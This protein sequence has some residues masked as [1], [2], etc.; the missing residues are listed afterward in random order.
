MTSDATKYARIEYERTFLVRADAD[1][2]EVVELDV[3]TLDDAYLRGTRLRLRIV[4]DSRTSKRVIKLTKKEESGSPYFRTISRILLSA[5]EATLLDSLAA[6]RLRKTR[7]IHRIDGR[8]FAIDAFEGQLR[9]LVLCSVEADGLD[10]LMAIEPPSY[11]LRE[12]T[13]DPFFSGAHLA[14]IDRSGLLARLGQGA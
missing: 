3:R 12:V 14:R 13:H 7:H 1:W 11:V 2:R 10:E 5:D 4:T 6:D 9:G 8:T